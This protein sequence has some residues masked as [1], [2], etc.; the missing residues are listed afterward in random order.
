MTYEA[1]YKRE[2]AGYKI[3]IYGDGKYV[4]EIL[5]VPCTLKQAKREAKQEINKL[6]KKAN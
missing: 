3:K 5:S 2:N 6:I 4:M 1:T